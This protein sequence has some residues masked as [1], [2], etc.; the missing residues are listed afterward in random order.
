M[1]PGFRPEPPTVPVPPHGDDWLD[2]AW[3]AAAAALGGPL[4]ARSVSRLLPHT[5]VS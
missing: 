4:A 5:D 2:L 1:T 3:F